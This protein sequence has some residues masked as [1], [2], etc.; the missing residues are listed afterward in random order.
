MFVKSNI[1]SLFPKDFDFSFPS[2]TFEIL[3][4]RKQ[5]KY[6][7]YGI[8]LDDLYMK[9]S[10]VNISFNSNISSGYLAPYHH[11]TSSMK[12]KTS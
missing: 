4:M 3:D 8:C 5:T 1:A 9:D 6:S 7:N 12:R 2:D 11:W 10:K